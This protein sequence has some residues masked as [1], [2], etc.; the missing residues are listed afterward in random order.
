MR[1]FWNGAAST[2]LLRDLAIA[3]IGMAT[4]GG[5]AYG[6]DGGGY[7]GAPSAIYAAPSAPGGYYGYPG[8]FGVGGIWFGGGRDHWNH[9]GHRWHGHHGGDGN[10]HGSR[11]NW[12]GAP[13]G[14]HTGGHGRHR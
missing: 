2:R 1:L 11:G 9:G 8:S 5:C 4:L 12:H 13:S 3:M 10:W 14:R 6:P 7:Y